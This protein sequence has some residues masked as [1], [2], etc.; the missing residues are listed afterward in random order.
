MEY[1]RRLL[2]GKKYS[3]DNLI[4]F[5]VLVVGSFG[6]R[7][8][9]HEVDGK[10]F[11]ILEE[12]FSSH[13]YHETV[14]HNVPRWQHDIAWAK[15]RAKQIHAYIKSAKESGRGV[16]ELTDKGNE[17]YELLVKKLQ[18]SVIIRKKA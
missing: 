18:R 2:Q 9:K 3:Q 15:E 1:A 8:Y 16:W 7:A 4:P 11:S 12:E 10:I 5:V 14:S 6:G 13:I 17:Y